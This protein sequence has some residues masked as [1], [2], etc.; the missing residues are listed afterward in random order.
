[1]SENHQ[2]S[3]DRQPEEQ[4]GNRRYDS[5]ERLIAWSIREGDYFV[6]Y[7]VKSFR[8]ILLPSGE[9]AD[10][11]AAFVCALTDRE[12]EPSF[13][14]TECGSSEGQSGGWKFHEDGADIDLQ[15]NRA[16]SFDPTPGRWIE[17]S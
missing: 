2:S 9:K 17:E 7:Q 8:E 4:L 10:V 5:Q 11:P 16:R 1:M 13:E 6:F 3:S 12:V 14:P 15:Y